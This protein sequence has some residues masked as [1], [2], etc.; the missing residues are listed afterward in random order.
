MLP[1]PLLCDHCRASINARSQ[2]FIQA[3]SARPPSLRSRPTTQKPPPNCA[4][5]AEICFSVISG[6]SQAQS[7]AWIC[8]LAR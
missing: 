1:L 8:S 7:S 4:E 2:S 6:P 3:F 5:A